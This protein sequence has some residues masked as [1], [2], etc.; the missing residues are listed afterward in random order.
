MSRSN[1]AMGNV[2]KASLMKKYGI[3][4]TSLFDKADDGRNSGYVKEFNMS[5]Y[6][7]FSKVN[8]VTG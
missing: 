5:D 4:D 6:K 1:P 8:Q 3:L 7:D 2:L